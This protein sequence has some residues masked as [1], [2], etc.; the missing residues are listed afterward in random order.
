LLTIFYCDG[1]FGCYINRYINQIENIKMANQNLVQIIMEERKKKKNPENNRS[2]KGVDP[3]SS[4]PSTGRLEVRAT[5]VEGEEAAAGSS[6]AMRADRRVWHAAL[7][8]P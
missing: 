7:L 8:H 2:A 5:E 4:S 6:L 3:R 1:I